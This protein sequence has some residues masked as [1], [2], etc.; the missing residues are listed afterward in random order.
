M[1]KR[2]FLVGCLLALS[3]APA[4]AQSASQVAVVRVVESI[5]KV[6]ISIARG[7]AEPGLIELDSIVTGKGA[8]QVTSGYQRVMARL[9][10]EGYQLQ[11]T[12][13][14]SALGSTF[15]SRSMLFVRVPKS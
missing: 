14:E 15:R 10:A 5:Y 9:C 3:S 13:G 7:G 12:I 6:H 1:R 4:L 11:K 8:L 2:F